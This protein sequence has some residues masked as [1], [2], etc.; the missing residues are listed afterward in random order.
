[1][2][3]LRWCRRRFTDAPISRVWLMLILCFACYFS[4]RWPEFTSKS[5][6]AVELKA[7]HR[8]ACGEKTEAAW[9]S[10]G[11]DR[12]ANWSAYADA[13][14]SSKGEIRW[15]KNRQSGCMVL[16]ANKPDS[17]VLAFGL[18]TRVLDPF[19]KYGMALAFGCGIGVGMTLPLENV[20][21]IAL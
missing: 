20:P 12:T 15:N 5:Y 10:D 3:Q 16:S 13:R 7:P 9:A 6:T 11:Q 4:A 8:N 21:H 14:A 18:R 2:E 17:T 1:M 19:G